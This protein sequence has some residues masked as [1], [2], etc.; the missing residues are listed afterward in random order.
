VLVDKF[1]LCWRCDLPPALTCASQVLLKIPSST[2]TTTINYIPY[3]NYGSSNCG[4]PSFPCSLTTTSGTATSVG[5]HSSSHSIQITINQKTRRV[6]STKRE[7]LN[8]WLDVQ[9][10][11]L[12]IILYEGRDTAVL[13]TP[14][15]SNS[16]TAAV[17]IPLAPYSRLCWLG[18]RQ[19]SIHL[20]HAPHT[21]LCHLLL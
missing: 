19:R 17:A 11:E 2:T 20:R 7:G 16:F 8:A 12:C 9:E 4:F 10:R 15:R 1:G 5:C 3:V 21:Q 13:K 14:T 18:Y 6:L